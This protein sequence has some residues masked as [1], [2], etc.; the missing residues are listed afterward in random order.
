MNPIHSFEIAREDDMTAL[1]RWL[2]GILARGDMVC[3]SGDIGAGK[4]VL[5]RAAIRAVTGETGD[6]PSPTF[7]IVQTY[8]GPF[9]VWHLDLYRLEEDSELDELGLDEMIGEA[10]IFIEW[11]DKAAALLPPAALFTKIS[12]G[13]EGGRTV[14]FLSEDKTWQDRFTRAEPMR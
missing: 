1:G 10:L 11:P 9:P 3:L 6:I 14:R 4:T 13:E 5:A 2:G 8:E 7:S 12:T